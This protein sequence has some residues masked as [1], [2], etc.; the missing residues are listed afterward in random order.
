MTS[1][2]DQARARFEAW[3]RTKKLDRYTGIIFDFMFD[4]WQA[5]ERAMA[6]R[7]AKV[8]DEIERAHELQGSSYLARAAHEVAKAIRSLVP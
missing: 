4:A 8:A 6:E 7:A 5:A 1:P 3:L 2:E